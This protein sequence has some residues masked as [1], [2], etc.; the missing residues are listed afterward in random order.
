M[1]LFPA[2]ENC[3]QVLSF[4]KINPAIKTIYEQILYISERQQAGDGKT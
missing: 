4:E 3:L 1:F 2:P